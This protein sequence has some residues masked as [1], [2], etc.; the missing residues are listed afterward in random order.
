MKKTN[1]KFNNFEDCI[2]F[3]ISTLLSPY[4]TATIFIVIIGYSYTETLG[5][6]M[7]WVLTFFLFGV[8]LPGIYILWLL[9][10][11]QVKNIHI[12]ERK[13]RQTPFLLIAA[14]SSIGT[15]LLWLLGAAKPVVTIAIIY[16]LNSIIIAVITFFWKIS[17][18]TAMYASIVTM[19]W[20]LFGGKIY[21][22]YLL[23]IPLIWSRVHRKRHTLGQAVFGSLLASAIT[24][25]IFWL[26]GYIKY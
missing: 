1:L 26:F 5:Q 22:L 18:H 6:F 25:L 14:S 19:A 15:L 23:L 4:V 7:P 24:A 17:I 9:E 20:I 11:G 13:D 10:T 21:L 3:I 12:T 2:A 8:V 16:S